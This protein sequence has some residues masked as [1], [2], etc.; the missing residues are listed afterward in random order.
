M[1]HCFVNANLEQVHNMNLILRTYECISGLKVNLHKSSM[2]GGGWW[3]VA[4]CA[5][6]LGC[7]KESWL[8]KY[9]GMPLG[10]NPKSLAF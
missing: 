10:G 1:L 6:I 7:R 3:V 2:V 8:L 4:M 5:K 9:M